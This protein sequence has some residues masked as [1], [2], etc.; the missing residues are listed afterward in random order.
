MHRVIY[1]NLYLNKSE[2][3]LSIKALCHCLISKI[4]SFLI[5]HKIAVSEN[6]QHPRVDET[7]WWPRAGGMEVEQRRGVDHEILWRKNAE[8]NVHTNQ[9]TMWGTYFIFQGLSY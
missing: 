1:K 6:R 9:S 8:G 3:I 4:F 7:L 5:V 2:T